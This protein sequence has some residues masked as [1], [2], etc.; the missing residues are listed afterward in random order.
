MQFTKTSSVKIF[1]M[2]TDLSVLS[3]LT[4]AVIYI[5]DRL[6]LY[7]PRYSFSISHILYSVT[8]VSLHQKQT[9]YYPA[10]ISQ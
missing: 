10:A 8:V 3:K 2:N 4:I 5:Y 9:L 1:S 7:R 6:Y